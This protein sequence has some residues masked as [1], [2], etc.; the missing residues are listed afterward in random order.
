[1]A[2]LNENDLA[3]A[4][5]QVR[6]M[7]QAQ[8]EALADELFLTQPNLLASVLA[9][10]LSGNEPAHVDELLHILFVAHVALKSTGRTL[11]TITEQEQEAEL[12]RM[13]AF[14]KFSEGLGIELLEESTKQHVARHREPY[15]FAYVLLALQESGI[16]DSTREESKFLVMVALNL[17][18]CIANAEDLT[19]PRP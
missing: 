18:G 3:T 5:L 10:M 6:G 16:L 15:L 13:V 19:G 8:K 14:I 4:A 9:L 7:N 1:M 2:K 17:V 11:R 12:N